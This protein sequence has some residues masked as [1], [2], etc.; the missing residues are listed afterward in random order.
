M[1]FANEW[2]S[3]HLLGKQVDYLRLKNF[4]KYKCEAT[5]DTIITQDRCCVPSP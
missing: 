5:I 2:S 4:F 3:F 1:F